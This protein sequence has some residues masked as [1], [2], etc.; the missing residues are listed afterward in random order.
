[1]LAPEVPG[2]LCLDFSR[3]AEENLYLNV[4]ILNWLRDYTDWG[5]AD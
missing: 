5:K 2:L 3:S 1:M 4:R